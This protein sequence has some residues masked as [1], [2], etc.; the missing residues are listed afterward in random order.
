M[1]PSIDS[2]SVKL[3]ETNFVQWQLQVRLIV[4]GYDFQSFLDGT[5]TAPLRLVASSDGSLV[6]NPDTS[7]LMRAV[8]EILL[9]ANVV[10]ASDVGSDSRGARGGRLSSGFRGGRRF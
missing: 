5:V 6:P 9:V 8:R 7:L 10:E 1:D 4:K 2:L 3:D